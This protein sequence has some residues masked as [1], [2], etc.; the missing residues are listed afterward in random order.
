VNNYPQTSIAG[1]V[2]NNALNNSEA[3]AWLFYQPMASPYALTAISQCPDSETV[4]GGYTP[5]GVLGSTAI[6][7]DML[8]NTYDKHNR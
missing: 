3:E 1:W 8:A 2:C 5:Q 4:D 7:N 6:T